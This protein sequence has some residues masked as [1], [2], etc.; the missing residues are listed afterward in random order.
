MSL[1][2]L[3]ITFNVDLV[4]EKY[5]EYNRQFCYGLQRVIQQEDLKEVLCYNQ[6]HS[7]SKV[8]IV[9]L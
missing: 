9:S 1:A 8:N 5:T 4:W 2:F 6:Y 3:V 7:V